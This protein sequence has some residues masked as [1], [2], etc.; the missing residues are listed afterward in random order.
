MSQQVGTAT[1]A[2]FKSE[3]EDSTVPTLVDFWAPW[4]GPCRAIAPIVEELARDF[5]GR[6]KVMK[7]NVDENPQ[8]P[9]NLHVTGIP[10]VLLFKNGRI[11]DQAVGSAP[12]RMFV[13]M[14]EKHLD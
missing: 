7:M 13:D 14:I 5:S 6:L 8:I 1:D 2:N 11:V 4:C 3:V 10:T 9:M 12:K